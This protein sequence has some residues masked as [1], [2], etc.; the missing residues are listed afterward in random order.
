MIQ[1]VSYELT[2]CSLTPKH[3]EEI[4]ASDEK[5]RNVIWTSLKRERTEVE[6]ALGDNRSTMEIDN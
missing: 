2:Q 1:K 6:I 3:G 5:L 4:D